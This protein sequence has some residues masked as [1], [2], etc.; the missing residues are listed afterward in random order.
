ME[1]PHPVSL[2]I[3]SALVREG[4]RRIL[5]DYGFRVE[6]SVAKPES[7]NIEALQDVQILISDY[8]GLS[9]SPL[10]ALINPVPISCNVRVVVLVD[11]FDVHGMRKLFEDGVYAC[12]MHDVHPESFLSVVHLVSLGEKVAPTEFI[13]TIQHS[14]LAY[15]Q[16][17]TLSSYQLSAREMDVLDR[18]AMGM[19]NKRISRDLSLSEATVK[20]TVKSIFRKLGVKNR[21]QAAILARDICGA[22]LGNAPGHREEAT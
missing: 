13:N 7:L 4:L 21:T 1:L 2:V 20:L 8:A 18:L 17:A 15:E 22:P 5:I 3:R 12:V 11:T 6:Q 16:P 19:S 14:P 10:S 9:S